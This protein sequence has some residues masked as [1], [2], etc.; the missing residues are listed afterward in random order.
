M[1]QHNPDPVDRKHSFVLKLCTLEQESVEENFPM[2]GCYTIHYQL[3]T[4]IGPQ[5]DTT[6]NIPA[7]S[8]S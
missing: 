8:V 1:T 7:A 4:V 2:L 3:H 6:V 5:E